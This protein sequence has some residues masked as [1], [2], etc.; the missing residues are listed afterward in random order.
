MSSHK[1]KEKWSILAEAGFD[2]DD[3][4]DNSSEARSNKGGEGS[5]SEEKIEK[6]L[7]WLQVNGVKETSPKDCFEGDEDKTKRMIALR[8]KF[9][10]EGHDLYSR[11]DM[12]KKDLRIKLDFENKMKG[13]E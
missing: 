9:R 1:L 2:M 12:S 7:D 11:R 4:W 6:I 5:I 8:E 13:S 10:S 3:V